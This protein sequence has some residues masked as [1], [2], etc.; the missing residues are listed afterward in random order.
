M[1]VLNPL[2]RTNTVSLISLIETSQELVRQVY[3][4][5]CGSILGELVDLGVL[6]KGYFCQ[7]PR[8]RKTSA[9]AT[10]KAAPFEAAS[11]VVAGG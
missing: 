5:P 3:Y 8:L 6:F 10:I 7:V 1:K 11:V 2:N 4:Y 9:R